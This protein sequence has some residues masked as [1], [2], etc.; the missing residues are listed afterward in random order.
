MPK[1]SHKNVDLLS[2]KGSELHFIGLFNVML[3]I[4]TGRSVQAKM[5]LHADL[6]LGGN[7]CSL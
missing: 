5:S 3:Y 4:I 6:R 1:R 2:F 7:M